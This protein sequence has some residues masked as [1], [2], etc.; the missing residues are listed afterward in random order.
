M[1]FTT[2]VWTDFGAFA[3]AAVLTIASAFFARAAP[4]EKSPK[5]LYE[6]KDGAA[7]EETQKQFSTRTQTIIAT[8]CA[9]A[10]FAISLTD[11]LLRHVAYQQTKQ[12]LVG[13]W[14]HLA[15]WVRR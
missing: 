15:T 8:F 6:D 2:L 10:G 12:E 9:F 13:G 5:A 1:E 3:L 4:R 7:T 11:G 14:A